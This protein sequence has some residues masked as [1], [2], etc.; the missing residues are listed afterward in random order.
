LDEVVDA[1]TDATKYLVELIKND[2]RATRSKDK[3]CP[4]K[5]NKIFA[6]LFE[7]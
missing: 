3:V 1:L 7:N 4:A 2:P 5:N 6:S